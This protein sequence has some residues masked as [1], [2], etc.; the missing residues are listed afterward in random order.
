MVAAPAGCDHRAMS[1]LDGQHLLPVLTVA[2]DGFATRLRT[3]REHDWERPTPCTEWDVRALVNHVVGANVRYQLLLRSAPLADVEAT[4]A[5]DHLGDDALAAFETTA[6]EMCASFGDR[7]VLDRSF[8]HA[9]GERTGREL[10]VMRILDIG[11]H[12]WDLAVAIGADAC[13]DPD[14]I[15]VGLSMS[16]PSDESEDAEVPAQVRLL[17]RSGRHPRQGG[18]S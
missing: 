16:S 10:L 13:I 11:V 4:R 2:V 14:V 3:V 17:L 8:R 6:G 1:G 9:A 15:A 18:G 5:L 12:T 7:T